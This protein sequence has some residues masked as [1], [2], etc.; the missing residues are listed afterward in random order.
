MHACLHLI[1]I[2]LQDKVCILVTHQLQY[3]K[4]VEH[5]VLMNM[6]IAE[7]QGP[8]RSLEA[9]NTFPLLA[10]LQQEQDD[11]ESQKGQDRIEDYVIDSDGEIVD[12][13]G[14][15]L[16]QKVSSMFNASDRERS[17]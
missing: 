16:Q 8:Y 3:L 14:D 4:D 17:S 1:S 6:G 9:S 13:E 15:T 10:V 11:K 7:A 5:I 12:G 2:F